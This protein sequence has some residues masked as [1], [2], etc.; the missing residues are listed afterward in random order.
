MLPV[1]SPFPLPTGVNPAVNGLLN[2]ADLVE[3]GDKGWLHKSAALAFNATVFAARV[4]RGIP[5]SYTYGGLYRT[6]AQQVE[7]FNARYSQVSLAVYLVTSKD[8]RRKWEGRY[9]RLRSGLSPSAVPGTSNHGLAIA[10]DM[11]RG[12][13]P[14]SVVPIDNDD[15]AWLVTNVHRFGW[16]YE[17]QVERWH[18]RYVQGDNFTPDVFRYVGAVLSPRLALGATGAD[19]VRAQTKLG[20]AADGNFGPQTE[21]TVKS[22]QAFLKQPQTGVIDADLWWFLK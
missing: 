11:A 22:W 18:I 12:L 7:T 6:Y 5:L 8:R 21:A 20:I 9:Y 4:E 14:S 17:S 2:T 1:V 13:V 15:H 16:S 10:W 19:V 3:V